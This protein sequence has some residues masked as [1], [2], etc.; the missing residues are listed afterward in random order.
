MAGLTYWLWLSSA[1]LTPRAK[2]TVLERFGDAEA[3]FHAPEGSF[4]SLPGLNRIEAD[5]LERRDLRLA[6]EIR[7]ECERQG[8]WMLSLQDAAYP[9]R[10]KHILSP[11]VVLYGKGG[12]PAQEN[13]VPIAVIGTRRCSPYGQRMAA[14]LG[15]ELARCGGTVVSLLTSEIETEAA[16]EALRAGGRV[17]G[18]LG[19]PH[20]RE[21]RRLAAE[22]ASQ[23]TLLSEYPPFTQPSSRFFRERNRIASG[24]SLGVLVVEAPEKSG[25]QLFVAEAAEQ[26]KEIFAV[27]GNA[28]AQGSAGTLRMIQEGAKLVTSGWEVLCEF[29]PLYPKALRYVPESTE[30]RI[31]EENREQAA[32]APYAAATGEDPVDKPPEKAYI[33]LKMQ[34]ENLTEDQLRIVSA[35][36]RNARHIDDII[37]ETGLPTAVVLAQLTRLQVQGFVRRE[38]GQRFSLNITKK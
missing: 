15:G 17:I 2:S 32:P 37:E 25:T 10:L 12:L 28:D 3:A 30:K 38:P 8:V 21:T 23:G 1:G 13:D 33:D 19:L 16:R 6:D 14:Q 34:L 27:P 35:I 31:E 29:Q 7:E 4:T 22:I 24:L 20:E 26:G 11:P 18:V 36:D 9:P 5:V